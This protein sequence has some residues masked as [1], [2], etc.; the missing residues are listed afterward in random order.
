MTEVFDTERMEMFRTIAF[1]PAMFLWPIGALGP[2]AHLQ[3]STAIANE[4]HFKLSQCLV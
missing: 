3:Y 2:S 4:T 1:C